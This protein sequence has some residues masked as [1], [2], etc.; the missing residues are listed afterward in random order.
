MDR[1][2]LIQMTL[3]VF[4]SGSVVAAT[5]NNPP[6]KVFAADK[7]EKC[8]GVAAAGKNDCG[9]PVHSCAGQSKVDRDPTEWKLVPIGTC[10]K[11]GGTSTSGKVG[12]KKATTQS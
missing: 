1:T 5:A 6:A 11:L 12:D 2:K 3:A 4:F 8:Y 9:T 10:Q 7:L